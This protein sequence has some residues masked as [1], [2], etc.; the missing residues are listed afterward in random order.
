MIQPEITDSGPEL[1][2]REA[3]AIIDDRKGNDIVFI[4]VSRVNRYFLYLLIATGSP[5]VHLLATARDLMKSLCRK[6][7]RILNRPDLDSGWILLDCGD[8][9][10]HLF[11]RETRQYYQ[12]EKLWGDAER[13]PLDP[14]D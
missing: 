13:I 10:I 11:T 12:L 4:D 7:R 5:H 2:A 3:A 14:G 6:G 8:V 1:L 9:V